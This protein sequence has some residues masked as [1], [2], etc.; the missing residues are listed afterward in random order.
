MTA[1]SG[2]S[3]ADPVFRPARVEDLDALIGLFAADALGGHGD[4]EDPSVRPAY[5]GA[6]ATILASPTDRLWVGE[7]DG[8]VVATA[9]T[10]LVTALPHRG[11]KRMIVEAVQVAAELRGRGIGERLMRR[12]IG[13]A[14][15]VGAGVVELTSNAS[16]LDAHRFYERLGFTRS[17]VGFKLPIDRA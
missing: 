8:R 7:I 13:K 17:H 11:R 3:T 12:L 2:R 16:R 4:S 9:Q 14:E 5:E 10:T 1:G 15:D 6:M